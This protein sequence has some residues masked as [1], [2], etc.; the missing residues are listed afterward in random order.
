[1]AGPVCRGQ[2]EELS[3]QQVQQMFVE[4]GYEIRKWKVS[5]GGCYEIDGFQNGKRVEVYIAP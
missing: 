4:K 5:S 1:M 2:G 3:E